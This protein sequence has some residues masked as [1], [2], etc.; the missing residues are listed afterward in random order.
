MKVDVDKLI[1]NELT[2]ADRPTYNDKLFNQ[3]HHLKVDLPSREV[4]EEREEKREGKREEKR[5]ES[6]AKSR[7]RRNV[8]PPDRY[9]PS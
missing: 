7:P 2:L 3:E 1:K 5:E 9:S 4:R 8:R 6:L